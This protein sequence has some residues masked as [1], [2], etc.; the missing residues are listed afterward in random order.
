[1]SAEK[2]IITWCFTLIELLIVIA[3]IA[4]LASLLLPS[5]K[6]ARDQAKSI[7]CAGN[8]KQIYTAFAS[9][10]SDYQGKVFPPR[11]FLYSGSEVFWMDYRSPIITHG[12]LSLGDKDAPDVCYCDITMEHVRVY[13]T[14][15]YA[16]S[17]RYGNY[18]YNSHYSN[19]APS[20]SD[21]NLWPVY[22]NK[23]PYLSRCAVFGDGNL[24]SNLIMANGGASVFAHG[25][26]HPVGKANTGFFD[27]HVASLKKTEY[28]SDTLD[29]FFSGK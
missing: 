19:D 1:M 8:I 24:G 26:S 12:Y 5:L 13:D 29:V 14:T 21:R 11:K 28:P 3:I 2:G 22:I 27:G 6:K 25:R 20:A 18:V 4:I 16:G 9:Y 15:R 10:S 23:M 17:L 7:R